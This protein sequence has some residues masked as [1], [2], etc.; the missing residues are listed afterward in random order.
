MD[1]VAE[2]VD[3]LLTV[4]AWLLYLIR[5]MHGASACPPQWTKKYVQI[6]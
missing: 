3:L 4:V 5:Y 2:A 6:P 1:T